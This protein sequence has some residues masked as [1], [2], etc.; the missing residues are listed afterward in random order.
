MEECTHASEK[1]IMKTTC[2]LS[3]KLGQ[4]TELNCSKVLNNVNII[5]EERI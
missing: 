2:T 5:V 3:Q 4:G 1:Q